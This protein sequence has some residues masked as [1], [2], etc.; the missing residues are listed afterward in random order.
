MRAISDCVYVCRHCE[1]RC[2]EAISISIAAPLL[3]ADRLEFDRSLEALCEQLDEADLSA[4]W[5]DGRSMTFEETVAY[6]L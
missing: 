6:V 4:A 2:A 1:A 3:P 5:S